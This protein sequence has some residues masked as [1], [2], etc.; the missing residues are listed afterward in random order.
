MRPSLIAAIGSTPRVAPY[1][2][3]SFQHAAGPVLRRMR[4]F[5]DA[6][7]FLDLLAQVRDVC[8][9]AA[10]RSNFI[11]GFPGEAEA[12]VA[13]LRDFLVDARLDAIGVFGYSDEDG[14]EAVRLDGHHDDLEIKARQ[15]DV[16]R[17]AEELTAQRAEE[18]IGE[19]VD[20]LLESVEAG[21]VEGRTGGQGPEVDGLTTIEGPPRGLRV[22][23]V[24]RA[25]VVG[26]SGVD[27]V[28]KRSRQ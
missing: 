11:V 12:D 21:V 8:P 25:K 18:R 10:V 3:L 1:F 23:D 5:G 19:A 13:T 20:V 22:G 16:E 7:R 26:S 15:G 27:L 14:T 2:D 4:R 24:V 9:T 6:E 28:A 17:L